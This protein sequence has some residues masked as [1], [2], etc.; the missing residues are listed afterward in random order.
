MIPTLFSSVDVSDARDR[1]LEYAET[2]ADSVV[3]VPGPLTVAE[4]AAVDAGWS[5]LHVQVVNIDGVSTSAAVR[6]RAL[7]RK[8]AFVGYT[9]DPHPLHGVSFHR[10][11]LVRD[12]DVYVA[13]SNEGYRPSEAAQCARVGRGSVDKARDAL[14]AL[15]SRTRVMKMLEA[16]RSHDLSGVHATSEALTG[17]DIELLRAAVHEIRSGDFAMWSQ[18]E[19]DIL[20]KHIDFVESTVSTYFVKSPPATALTLAMGLYFAECGLL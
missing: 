11:G 12:D 6:L 13:L 7:L 20:S 17:S 16:V 19:V 10:R 15:S 9:T 5:P 8:G 2:L 14:P 18:R 4:V 1:A 3:H